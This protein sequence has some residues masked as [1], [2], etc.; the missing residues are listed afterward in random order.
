MP[1]VAVSWD[2]GVYVS[3]SL[4]ILNG[5]IPLVDYPS[6]SPLFHHYLAMWLKL[7]ENNVLGARIAVMATAVGVAILVYVMGR[8]VHSRNA[9]LIA[10]AL[11]LFTPIS[12]LYGI[13]VK[14]QFASAIF[15]LL[16]VFLLVRLY[17][18]G[19]RRSIAFVLVG[20]CL[21]LGFLV[22]RVVIAYVL[23]AVAFTF[24]AVLYSRGSFS[25]FSV[26]W[27]RRSI[28]ESVA[29]VASFV[30]TLGV[31]YLLLARLD[32][33]AASILMRQ[34]LWG[35][36]S[37]DGSGDISWVTVAGTDISASA[38]GG[39]SGLRIV[40]VMMWMTIVSL[41]AVLPLVL[42]VP[43]VLR[44]TT[45]ERRESIVMGILM[46]IIA[47][48]GAV[49][50]YVYFQFFSSSLFLIVPPI[51]L[52][53]GAVVFAARG[54]SI[55]VDRLWNVRLLLPLLT[56]AA[57]GAGYL[58]RD[59]TLFVAYFLDFLPLLSIIAGV[60]A[61][62][63]R[64]HVHR[65]NRQQFLVFGAVVLL[66]AAP[67]ATVASLTFIPARATFGEYPDRL[68]RMSEIE[69]IAD[70]LDRRTDP[71]D[72]ILVAEPLYTI[73]SESRQIID[74]SRG[75]Y[76]TRRAPNSSITVDLRQQMRK[77][78]HSGAVP[79][80]IMDSR[81]RSM[82]EAS[83]KL[84]KTVETKYC[85]VSAGGVYNNQNATLFKYRRTGCDSSLNF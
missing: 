3:D 81:T 69:R 60:T 54:P 20:N 59:R 11:F 31:G 30:T 35:L 18:G 74:L 39:G 22:R 44:R 17:E 58:I 14:T 7:F 47:L 42:V 16:A 76:L 29:I 73:N 34:Q 49:G 48:G 64:R 21:G 51:F 40:M 12:A 70:D 13:T 6:R 65:V 32:L 5:G 2:T 8:E 15:G 80:M 50:T 55:P 45:S 43:G 38:P 84:A 85:E 23:A 4:Q 78:V 46:V 33:E 26:G 83:P 56:L 66:L 61:E 79:Y 72:E 71:G 52:V 36:V 53:V 37:S 9:G 1:A 63:F 10:T 68:D 28:R 82:L 62:V 77:V 19:R 75:V 27:L 41:P 67:F 57:L 25:D 24:A